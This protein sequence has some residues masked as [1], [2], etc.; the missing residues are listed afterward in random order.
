MATKAD[1]ASLRAD[2]GQA[3]SVLRTDVG[4]AISTLAIHI[5]ERFDEIAP[6]LAKVD[7]HDKRLNYVENML[8]ELAPRS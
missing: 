4:Q 1:L 3:I 2:V 8:T 5:D 6:V 7:S